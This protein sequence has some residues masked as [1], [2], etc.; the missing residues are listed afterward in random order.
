MRTPHILRAACTALVL[1]AGLFV[2]LAQAAEGDVRK[3][4][5]VQGKVTIQHGEIKNLDM[6]AMTMVYRAKPMTLLEGLKAGDHVQFEAAKVD[7]QYVVTAIRK[8][9]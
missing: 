6:P 8:G 7:G 3:V 2:S 5:M 9:R 4:D 1:T